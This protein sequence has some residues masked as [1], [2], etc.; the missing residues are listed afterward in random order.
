MPSEQENDQ[1]LTELSLGHDAERTYNKF[2]KP[3]IDQKKVILFK[4]F[5]DLPASQKEDLIEV[6][7][8]L[9]TVNTFEREILTIIETGK[10]AA[11]S[12]ADQETN[13]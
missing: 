2:I 13:K 9:D 5:Q 3:F 4:S 8:M 6:R 7:R 12:I 1:L 10:M 11:K